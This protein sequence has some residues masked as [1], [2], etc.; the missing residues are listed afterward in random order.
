MGGMPNKKGSDEERGKFWRSA[1]FL[2]KAIAG[3]AVLIGAVAGVLAIRNTTRSH[4]PDQLTADVSGLEGARDF[5]AFV[6]GHDGQVVYL[7]VECDQFVL[8][9]YSKHLRK[10]D[11]CLSQSIGE[12]NSKSGGADLLITF[13][14]RRDA[15]RG[16]NGPSSPE[17]DRQ[18]VWAW[19]PYR[20]EV[21][22][23]LTNGDKGAGFWFVKGY[24]EVILDAGGSGPPAAQSVELVAVPP[25]S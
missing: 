12:G 13:D 17:S 16:W 10:G 7:N 19:I 20:G 2:W 21:K 14:G 24:Y 9:K 8:L 3:A 23:T 15:Q 1:T 22:A 4:G 6:K 11:R 18:Q 25:P 5:R